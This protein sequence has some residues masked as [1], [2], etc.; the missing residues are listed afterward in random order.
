[1]EQEA[2]RGKSNFNI[3]MGSRTPV[4]MHRRKDCYGVVH[5]FIRFASACWLVSRPSKIEK[6]SGIIPR[7]AELLT[8]IIHTKDLLAVGAN[9]PCQLRGLGLVAKKSRSLRHLSVRFGCQ[10]LGF[11]YSFGRCKR[12]VARSF[13]IFDS[14]RFRI[15]VHNKVRR[16]SDVA[17]S[18]RRRDNLP[19]M[20]CLRQAL[21]QLELCRRKPGY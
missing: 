11:V 17:G 4:D 1:M 18:K 6:E 2:L 14:P 10:K 20:E 9:Y 7:G 15:H 3:H 8:Q 19:C 21:P 13:E 12:R 5:V 16:S